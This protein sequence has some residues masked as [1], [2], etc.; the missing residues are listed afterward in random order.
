[1]GPHGSYT[2]AEIL[3]QPEVWAAAL[4]RL[5]AQQAVLDALAHGGYDSVV[6]T[7]CGSPYY[8]GLAA[9]AAMQEAAGIPARAVPA[10]ELWLDPAATLPAGGRTLL[11]AVSRS[12]VTTETLRACTAFLGAGRGDLLTLSCDPAQPLATMGAL[13]LTFPEAQ[14]QSLAQTRAF[15]TLYLAALYLAAR[16]GGHEEMLAGLAALPAA[17]ERQLAS[18]H[19]LARE[20]GADQAIDRFYF[21][22]SGARYGLA[23]ELSLKLKEMALTHCEPF[24]FLEFRHG[25]RAM[26]TR[27]ALVVGLLSR[28]NRAHEAAVLAEVRAQGARTLAIGAADAD[29]AFGAGLPDVA[30]GP[31]YLPVGQLLACERAVARGFDPDRPAN[32]SAVIRLG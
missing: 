5:D 18:Y 11:V 6:F 30:A 7:G 10:G 25:P 23:C 3:S 16:W 12:G 8:L 19:G 14:E 4:R 24:H 13:N 15:S 17:A 26:A 20:L 32:L 9:A 2:R 1:M 28:R 21:L 22:G 27:G 29:V 31:L